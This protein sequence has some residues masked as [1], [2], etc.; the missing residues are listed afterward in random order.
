MATA[1]TRLS[2]IANDSALRPSIWRRIAERP[3]APETLLLYSALSFIV[4]GRNL[5]GHFFDRFVGMG[6]DA[7]LF[8]FFFEWWRHALANH[9][10]PFNLTAVWYPPGYNLAWTTCVPLAAWAMMPIEATLGPIAAYNV[11]IMLCP[12]LSAWTAFLLCRYITRSYWPSLLGGYIF[13]F[14]SYMLCHSLGHLDLTMVFLFP[15]AAY[16]VMRWL[17]DELTDVK[18][19]ALFTLLLLGQFLSALETLAAMTL[20]GATFL[21]LLWLWSEQNRNFRA[22]ILKLIPL[23]GV[24]FAILAVVMSPYLY[25]FFRQGSFLMA[26]GWTYTVAARPVSLFVPIS[27][28]IFGAWNSRTHIVADVSLWEAGEYVGIPLFFLMWN[29][30]RT[31]WSEPAVKALIV[32]FALACVATFGPYLM[33]G[34]RRVLPLPWLVVAHLPLVH[35]ILPG[36]LSVYMFLDLAIVAAMWLSSPAHSFRLR[37]SAA[38]AIIISLLPNPSASYWTRTANVPPFFR[39]GIFRK[40]LSPDETVLILPFGNL[41]DSGLWQAET[42]MYFRMAGGYVNPTIPPSFEQYPVIPNLYDLVDMPDADEQMKA[43]LV[44][45]DIH[46]VIVAD[47]SANLWQF[48]PNDPLFLIRRIALSPDQKQTIEAFFGGLGVAP[49]HVGGVSLYQVPLGNLRAYETIPPESLQ[50]RVAAIRLATLMVAAN[51]YVGKGYDL[52][53]LTP[54]RAQQLGLLP[55]RWVGGVF[56]LPRYHKRPIQDELVLGGDSEGRVGVGVLGPRSVLEKLA[57]HYSGFAVRL[58]QKPPHGYAVVNAWMFPPGLHSPSFGDSTQWVLLLEFQR[59]GLAKAAKVAEQ[60]LLTTHDRPIARPAH[61]DK[62]QKS[63]A[64]A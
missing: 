32:F 52:K 20:A 25:Y 13:G 63:A 59:D 46:A 18:F 62:N 58:A 61:A 4:F 6:F 28:N 27:T 24:S 56:A 41:A 38:T 49:I 3:Y 1:P 9:L 35:M 21:S 45:K 30:A 48:V 31:R 36:R 10:N 43:F 37:T 33:I 7:Q 53:L 60:V 12:A 26:A 47:G 22:R 40:Y 5:I 54:L 29:F 44:Q 16:L 11:A 50:T 39:D 57:R 8:M 19:V 2:T 42:K 34:S 23:V 51:Q 15:L 55:P 17:A 14:S 64:A